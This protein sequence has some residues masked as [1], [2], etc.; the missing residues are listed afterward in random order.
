MAPPLGPKRLLILRLRFCY[1]RGFQSEQSIVLDTA[2]KAFEQYPDKVSRDNE[3]VLAIIQNAAGQMYLEIGKMDLARKNLVQACELRLKNLPS[4]SEEVAICDNNLGIMYNC[5]QEYFSALKYAEQCLNIR[6]EY[7]KDWGNAIGIAHSN[8]G[9]VYA[10]LG[11]YAEAE[12]QYGKCLDFYAKRSGDKHWFLKTDDYYMYGD[13]YLAQG[14]VVKA[15]ENYEKARHFSID[16][17]NSSTDPLAAATLYKLGRLALRENDDKAAIKYLRH[18]LFICELN[19][20]VIN[21]PAR[22]SFLLS[23]ALLLSPDPETRAEGE[24]RRLQAMHLR[25]TIEGE[26]YDEKDQ[27]E[28]AYDRLMSWYEYR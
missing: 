10:S 12:E 19:K 28:E 2:S 6:I 25:Q 17:G 11:R 9:R 7:G 27:S 18:S 3:L 22:T 4:N 1:E 16:V 13:L 24:V 15:K 21:I 26:R 14:D 8:L 5:A 23:K 20:S